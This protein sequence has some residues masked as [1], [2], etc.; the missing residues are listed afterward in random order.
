MVQVIKYINAQ[1]QKMIIILKQLSFKDNK[2]NT[3]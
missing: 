2:I 1:K 3:E